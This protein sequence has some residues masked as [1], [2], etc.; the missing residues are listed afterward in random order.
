MTTE[1]EIELDITKKNKNKNKKNEITFDIKGD[2]ESGLDKS[3]VNSLRRVLLSSIPS[4]AFRTK[5]DQSDIIIKK[6]N[7][8]LHNEF[9]SDRI[10]LIPLY[11]NPIDYEKQY[12]FHLQVKSSPLTPLSTITAKDFKIYPLK[13]NIVIDGENEINLDNYDRTKELSDKEKAEIF[14]PFNFRGKDEY[15]IITELKSTKSSMEQELDVY[16]VPSLSYGYEDAKWQAVSCAT[17]SFKRNE[18]LFEKVFQ[19][20]VKLNNVAKSN[21]AK[22]KKELWI[23]E[24]ERYFH[25]DKKLE[26]YWYSFKIDSVHFMS[27]KELFILSNQ[28]MIDQLERLILEFPKISTGE[29]SILSLEEID[30]GIFKITVHGYDDTVGNILQSFISVNMIDDT[31]I[32]SVCGYKKKHPL[33]DIINFTISLNKR[34]Q[35]FK[36]PKPQQIVS[37]TE[38]FHT[39]CN[40]LIQTYSSIKAE[41]DKKL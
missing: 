26:P 25:R 21:Q 15:C 17:Y 12:L 7:T 29:K 40:L 34:N 10:G 16:G 22:F 14:R 36:M 30:E 19:E 27:S 2:F 1:I 33:E 4:I 24:S 28:I 35:V 13:K 3:I 6:N 38:I 18:E 32:I 41:A 39:S 11:I 8:S 23:S 20:K 37:I 31:S 5:I 9:I